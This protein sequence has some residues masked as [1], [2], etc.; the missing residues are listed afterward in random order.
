[1]KSAMNPHEAQIYDKYIETGIA[2]DST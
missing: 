1:V 2:F